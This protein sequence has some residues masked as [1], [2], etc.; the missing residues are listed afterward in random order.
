MTK[1][2][3]KLFKVRKDGSIGSLFMNAKRKLP[4]GEW[5]AAGNHHRKGFALRPAWHAT[6]KPVAPHLKPELSSGEVRKWFVVEIA[7][8]EELV[9][10]EI[11][12]GKWYLAQQIKIIKEHNV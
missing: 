7:N 4:V 12:G 8:F 6:D 5:I 1:R 9:R 3:F 2:V 11:Q 10:P